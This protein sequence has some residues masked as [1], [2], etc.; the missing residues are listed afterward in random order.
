MGGSDQWGNITTGT[1]LI[2]VLVTAKFAATCP[3]ITNQ[4]AQSLGKAKATMYGWTPSVHLSFYQY[5]LNSSDR[6][7]EN[8]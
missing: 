7:A 3:L 6:D 5:W 1:E 4:M 8:W 2:D